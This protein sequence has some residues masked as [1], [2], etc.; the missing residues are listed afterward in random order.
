MKKNSCMALSMADGCP[1]YG[2]TAVAVDGLSAWLA[3]LANAVFV[4]EGDLGWLSSCA[5]CL[6]TGCSRRGV[7]DSERA[8][9][10]CC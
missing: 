5:V 9:K 6:S 4:G 8:S 2:S 10:S 3:A 7:E 1:A